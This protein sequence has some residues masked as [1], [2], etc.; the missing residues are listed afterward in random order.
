MTPDFR[1]RL[2]SG[3]LLVGCF[4]K[5]PSI[6]VVEILG[7]AGLDFAVIDQ[8]HA[9]I[10]ISQM[11]LLALAGR[12][13]GLP[14]L[15]RRWG[16]STDWIAPLLDLGL[17]GVMVGIAPFD[18]QVHDTYFVVAHLHYVLIGGML[19]P[20]F[21]AAYYY[22][23]VISGRMMLP[24]LGRWTFW[25]MFLGFHIAFF[26]MHFTG[27]L[28]MPRRVYTYPDLPGWGTLNLISTLGGLISALAVLVFIVNLVWSARRGAPAGD[29][30]WQAW[31]LEWATT[32]PP[33]PHNF[34][35]VPP[36]RSRRGGRSVSSQEDRAHRI[37]F[38]GDRVKG[39]PVGV[40]RRERMVGEGTSRPSVDPRGNADEAVCDR[41]RVSAYLNRQ[42]PGYRP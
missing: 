41:S 37:E 24:K 15:S 20:M 2:K 8:E 19:F 25:L 18:W 11:D 34:D 12:A 31:T 27:L 13:S 3:E 32:S 21:A 14:L 42:R 26:P 39:C 16:R 38:H 6:H 40:L 30:P 5:T 33:P 9:P 7:H 29:N 23:P 36:V 4:V 1:S 35:V 28:G 22:M 10:E 17:T